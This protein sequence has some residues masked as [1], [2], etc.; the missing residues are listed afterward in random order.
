MLTKK[1][2]KSKNTLSSLKFNVENSSV[3]WHS[4]REK[5]AIC[6]S[7]SKGWRTSLTYCRRMA[8]IL[9]SWTRSFV[10]GLIRRSTWIEK[11]LKNHLSLALWRKVSRGTFEVRNPSIHGK[12]S[13]TL[14]IH[15]CLRGLQDSHLSKSPW[16]SRPSPKMHFQKGKLTTST[17]CLQ[18]IWHRTK[19]HSALCRSLITTRFSTSVASLMMS[20]K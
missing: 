5:K 6:S 13:L 14:R 1:N 10:V 15:F 18:E 12:V 17:R 19:F 7:K 20:L 9:N 11:S 3:S 8:K 4:W 2:S 16:E